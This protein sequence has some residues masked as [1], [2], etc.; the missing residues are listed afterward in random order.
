MAT[1][2]RRTSDLDSRILR[3]EETQRFLAERHSNVNP[4]YINGTLNRRP[5]H[6]M[7]EGN[8]NRHGRTRHAGSNYYRK[9]QYH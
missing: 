4:N 3:E 9:R 8:A 6:L 7:M 1:Y 2:D 5:A